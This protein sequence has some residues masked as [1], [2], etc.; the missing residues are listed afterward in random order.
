MKPIVKTLMIAGLMAAATQTMAETPYL[1]VG[2]GYGRVEIDC[3]GSSSCNR[4][5]TAGKI[6]LGYQWKNGWAMEVAYQRLGQ[7]DA[8]FAT[9]KTDF[10]ADALSL[11]AA[12][13][14]DFNPLFWGG[15]RL[16]AAHVEAEVEDSNGSGLIS[17]NTDGS[18]QPIGGLE[19][20]YRVNSQLSVNAGVDVTR[21]KAAGVTKDVNTWLLGLRFD[22]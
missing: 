20:G 12:Y 11:Q 16:G 17:R 14:Y 22:Y 3:G 5:D 21:A 8:T 13:R 19:L 18:T 10:K 4:G 7:S 9:G 1:G 2:L 6:L 15:V